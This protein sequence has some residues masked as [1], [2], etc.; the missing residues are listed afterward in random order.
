M[1]KKLIILI[2]IIGALLLAIFFPKN[3]TSKEEVIFNIEKGQSS[4]EI[5]LNLEKEGLIRWGPVF[6]GYVLVKGVSGKLQAG[7]YQL[8]PSM[9]IPQ[10]AKKFANGDVAE[11][12]I[13]IIEGWNFRNIGFYFENKGMFQAEELWELA[14]FPAVDYSE[15]AD[16][17]KPKDFSQDYDFL[18]EKPKNIGFEGYL[19][20][21]TYQVAIDE[22][23]ES[24]VRK[25]LDNFD[26]KTTGFREEIEKQNKTL[27][28]IITMASL[29]EK[30]VR[31]KEDKE[32]VS[33]IFW[34]R[35]ALG[36][37]LE[38]CATIAYIKG[39]D[40]WRYS[41]EDTRI[42]SPYNTY[43]NYGLPA[44]PICNPGLESIEAALYPQESEY[45]Y[46]LSTPEGETI[47]SKT[48]EEHNY[49]KVK[50]LR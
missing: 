48:L 1:R 11:E 41:F 30:E 17:P 2:L 47:F 34:K 44:G 10:I 23:L 19:F 4:R 21:D 29:I 20:P 40:Q 43:L 5:A 15:A 3:L 38:S 25:M 18:K 24:I 32:I 49:A 13:T 36:K 12:T 16:L 27:F 7:T 35:I 50:Y 28:E 39:I 26:K 9:N 46:H 6:R 22:T 45:W 37:P 42:E 31:V 14:G 8:S 33:G